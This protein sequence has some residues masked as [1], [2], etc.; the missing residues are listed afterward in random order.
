VG[1][2]HGDRGNNNQVIG[3]KKQDADAKASI[4]WLTSD[5]AAS[6]PR[7]GGECGI[8]ETRANADTWG[9]RAIKR[10]TSNWRDAMELFHRMP[11]DRAEMRRLAKDPDA[12]AV[13]RMIDL[14][15]ERMAKRMYT[16][17]GLDRQE[18]IEGCWRLMKRGILCLYDPEV[19]DDDEP[20]VQGA[21]TP[22]QRARARFVGA[23]LYAIRQYIRRAAQRKQAHLG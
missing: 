18:V 3:G 8:A 14:T 7:G 1:L 11:V 22:G 2:S 5:L 4:P 17:Y 6:A 23:R 12:I 15:F 21:V 20:L 19:D 13:V 10:G 16:E 9:L